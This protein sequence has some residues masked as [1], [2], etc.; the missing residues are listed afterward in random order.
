[1][2][3]LVALTVFYISILLRSLIILDKPNINTF[4][5]LSLGL[6]PC[7]FL[8]EGVEFSLFFFFFDLN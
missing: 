8:I 7:L 4:I 2:A 6:S 3:C 5:Q 1:M